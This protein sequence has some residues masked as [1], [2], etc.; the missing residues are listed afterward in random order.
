MVAGKV[1]FALLGFLYVLDGY[2]AWN[3]PGQVWGKCIV[4]SLQSKLQWVL[5]LGV[6]DPV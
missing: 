2:E 5:G 3:F 6:R 1:D 4:L